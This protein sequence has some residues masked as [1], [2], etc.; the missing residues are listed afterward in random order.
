MESAEQAMEKRRSGS[1]Q[2]VERSLAILEALAARR[3]PMTLKEVGAFCGLKLST[4][5][6]L[7]ATLV[8]K[9][10]AS[11]DV[12]TGKYRLGIKTFQIGNA[13]LY[14][15]DLRSMVRPH[16]I[17]LVEES[18][19]TANLAVLERT[20]NGLELVYIDQ[21]ESPRMIRT[22]AMIG[23]QVPVHSTGSGKI[24]LAFLEER[25]LTSLLKNCQLTPFTPN[26]ITDKAELIEEL[27]RTR[28]NGYALDLEETENG[29]VC[30]AAPICNHAD[31]V[32]AA[33][34]ISGPVSRMIPPCDAAIEVV[35]NTARR[36]SQGLG[37]GRLDRIS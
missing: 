4:T 12:V 35:M 3:E 17:K 5:H 13:A 30:V 14:S 28:Q 27:N 36:I 37:A 9:G 33:I 31:Q 24:L 18:Q 25:E 19:E 32:I 2:S 16:L 26:T 20:N 1:V 29:V 6:R 8:M 10:F 11:Q 15:L 7:L 23:G 22:S 34:S 21:F